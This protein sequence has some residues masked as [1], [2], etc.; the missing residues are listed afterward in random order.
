MVLNTLNGFITIAEF[1]P[2]LF[3]NNSNVKAIIDKLISFLNTDNSQMMTAA[4]SIL[5]NITENMDSQ[6]VLLTDPGILL[7]KIVDYYDKYI[8]YFQN[9]SKDLADRAI[10]VI[11]NCIVKIKN[12]DVIM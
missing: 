4:L 3:Y 6:C 5:K 12:K 7:T 9:E 1:Y 2:Y 11:M 10:I 8:T